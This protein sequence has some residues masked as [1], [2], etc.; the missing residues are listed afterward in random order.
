MESPLSSNALIK[1]RTQAWQLAIC[2]FVCAYLALGVATHSVRSYHWLMLLVI[3]GALLSAER[4]RRFFLDWAPLFAFWLV[5]DRLRLL[6]P[7]LYSRVAV[8][9]PYSIEHAIFG[10][11]ANGAI[12]AHEAQAWLT[13][14]QSLA[15]KTIEWAAQL[16]YFSHLFVVPLAI[17]GLWLLGLSRERFRSSFER[18]IRAFTF[19]S[20]SAV[21]IYLLIPVAPPWWVTL[22]GMAKPTQALILNADM[23]LAMHGPLIQAMI[24]NASQWFAAVPSLHGAYPVLLFLLARPI[25]NRAMLV[26]LVMYGSAMWAATVVLNQHYVIDLIAGALLAIAAYY[27][28]LLYHKKQR[29]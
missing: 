9:R 24:R 12:P 23:T 20:F 18:H 2:A 28:E 4:G 11:L 7:L 1:H 26:G 19:L 3:P 8:E 21:A 29:A 5:Y 15:A 17:A 16:V 22:N 13:A 27:A 10:W 25:A 6:Q 14:D